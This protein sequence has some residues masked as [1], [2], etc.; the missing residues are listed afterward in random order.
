MVSIMD[1]VQYGLNIA[2]LHFTLLL[3]ACELLN[4]VSF[5]LKRGIE[6]LFD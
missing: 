1:Q 5:L 3:F 6:I 4:F 2:S